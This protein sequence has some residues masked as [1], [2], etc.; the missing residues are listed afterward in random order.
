MNIIK[1]FLRNVYFFCVGVQATAQDVRDWFKRSHRVQGK[2]RTTV[3]LM[4]LVLALVVS[5]CGSRTAPA[6]EGE[7]SQSS[8]SQ[9]ETQEA[10]SS[11]QEEESSSSK[12]ESETQT[13][14][15]DVDLMASATRFEPITSETLATT[16]EQR[17]Q[18]YYE[19]T[20]DVVYTPPEAGDIEAWREINPDVVGWITISNT[21]INYPL[22]IGEYTDYYTSRGY[23][24]EASRNGVIWFDSDT[25][26]DANGEIISQNA[27]LYG[28]NWT[29][30]WR[31]TQIGRSSDVMFAQLAAYDH[32]DFAAEN[33]YI[34]IKTLGGDHVY[35]IFSVFY[36]DLSFG[37]NYADGSRIPGIISTA[38]A[39]SIHDFN[40][41]MG[42]NDQ[43]ITLSTCTR[44]LGNT[45]NQRFVV[46]AKKI[47]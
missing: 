9:A 34:R 31:P 24:K 20:P 38:K 18:T 44:V 29:N 6:Q 47:S 22:V 27:V 13:V 19:T 10:S 17:I 2:A 32:A 43:F 15:A 3:L 28:H 39:K 4:T 30:C 26:F 35:Q 40:V 42:P 41:N 12:E 11:S 46:M 21:N 8:A 37:Y 1:E 23:Y 25:K 7:E 45:D 33:P 16:L 5:G 36:T 14:T